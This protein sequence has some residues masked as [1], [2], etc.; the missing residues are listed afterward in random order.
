M[1]RP[2]HNLRLLQAADMFSRQFRSLDMTT[3]DLEFEIQLV[4]SPD[5]SSLDS[6]PVKA[7][8]R[9]AQVMRMK[10][11]LTILLSFFT[12]L[13]FAQT[14]LVPNPSF[15]EYVTCPNSYYMLPNNWYTCSGDP[16]YFNACDITN[17]FSVPQNGWGYQQAADGNAYGGFYGI[18][19][20]SI[21]C[22]KEYL[23][24]QLI[25]PLQIN[26]KYFVSFKVCKDEW[27]KMAISNIG[28][29][30][31]TKSYR[32]FQPYNI[33]SLNIPTINFAHIVDTTII[34]DSINWTTIRGS[35]IADSSYQYILIGDFYDSSKTKVII[36]D[37]SNFFQQRSYY[38][39]DQVCVSEDSLTCKIFENINALIA[40]NEIVK[41]FPNPATNELTID[42]TTPD[43]YFFELYN[44]LGAKRLSFRL[45]S[46]PQTI[47][48]TAVDSGVYVYTIVDNKGDKIKTDKLIIIK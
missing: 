28:L 26:H 46:G 48:L 33:D 15:E 37:S 21:P 25:S 11:H 4:Q 2:A 36:Y 32:V 9:Y 47:D 24:C 41:I 27:H 12:P 45:D 16:D 6:P 29:L 10:L 44:L 34:Q 22:S 39:V 20:T 17:S 14:N 40:N 35:V 1:N 19:F 31:S 30:F 43:K 8:H 7:A 42:L 18:S 5:K 23:G 13:I 3:V 38:Y